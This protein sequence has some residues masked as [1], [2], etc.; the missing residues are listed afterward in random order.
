MSVADMG[1]LCVAG[2]VSIMAHLLISD[3]I[4]LTVKPIIDEAA[5]RAIA[6]VLCTVFGMIWFFQDTQKIKI[7]LAVVTIDHQRTITAI[8]V[9]L[10]TIRRM[11]GYWF[12]L[13]FFKK[14]IKI[15]HLGIFMTRRHL[16]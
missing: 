3:W 8:T 9:I 5:C 12:C 14:I 13:G 2:W 10:S 11:T 4:I 7:V 6:G 15:K 16:V 1:L